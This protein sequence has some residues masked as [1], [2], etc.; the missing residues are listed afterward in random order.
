MNIKKIVS[1]ITIGA[2]AIII[3]FGMQYALAQWAPAPVPPPGSNVPAPINVGSSAQ[4]KAG[5]LAIGTG[6]TTNL[7]PGTNEYVSGILNADALYTQL[8]TYY[9]GTNSSKGKVLQ[10]SDNNGD[11][12]WVATSTLGLGG[13]G[14]GSNVTKIVAGTN[15]TISPTTGVGNV[16]INSAGG[17]SGTIKGISFRTTATASNT[18][19]SNS[20]GATAYCNQ[21]EYVTGGGGNVSVFDF[22]LNSSGP[23]KQ[24][25]SGI[26][27]W[28]ETYH[29]TNDQSVNTTVQVY[30]ICASIT[31]Y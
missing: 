25:S 24:Y 21:G 29:Q 20:N 13:G 26:Q 9:D 17:G 1:S 3:G 30:A 27:G 31:T 12:E 8:F 14:S 2:G 10:S 19:T 6:A 5:G 15:V 28:S 18:Q 22:L 16:T 23:V 11:A 7:T 4:A